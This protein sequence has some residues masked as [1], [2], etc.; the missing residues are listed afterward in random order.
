VNFLSSNSIRIEFE[1]EIV[2]QHLGIRLVEL[3]IEPVVLVYSPREAFFFFGISASFLLDSLLNG[4]NA[5]KSSLS[6]G[7]RSRTFCLR[8]DTR[9]IRLATLLRCPVYAVFFLTLH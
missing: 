2:E 6:S 4:K 9:H 5:T 3:P 7:F 8:L 1:V